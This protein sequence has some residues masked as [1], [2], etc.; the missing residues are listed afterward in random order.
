MQKFPIAVRTCRKQSIKQAV[1][2]KFE[3]L[4]IFNKESP[5]LRKVHFEPYFSNPIMR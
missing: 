3:Q 2:L 1:V 4:K 5:Q